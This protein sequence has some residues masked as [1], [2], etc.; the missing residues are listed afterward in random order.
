MYTYIYACM[1]P[2]TYGGEF[3]YLAWKVS[4]NQFLPLI[5]ML[6]CPDGPTTWV[7]KTHKNIKYIKY[8]K[9]HSHTLHQNGQYMKYIKIKCT[10]LCRK[11][12][13][14]C[15]RNVIKNKH[16]D[17]RA[18]RGPGKSTGIYQTSKYMKMQSNVTESYGASILM[19]SSYLCDLSI[20]VGF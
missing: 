4:S 20:C 19:Y 15:S 2:N 13:S 9:I 14:P 1:E 17:T 11:G 6:T 8:I 5:D 12:P 18:N 7:H 10:G 16:F 3:W